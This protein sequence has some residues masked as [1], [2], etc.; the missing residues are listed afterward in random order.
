MLIKILE[1]LIEAIKIF[2]KLFQ[3][4]KKQPPKS[5]NYTSYKTGNNTI[6]YAGGNVRINQEVNVYNDKNPSPG[7]RTINPS[8]LDD[9]I[10]I[11]IESVAIDR[12]EDRYIAPDAEERFEKVRQ[13][14]LEKQIR[15]ANQGAP[16][17][18]AH[19]RELITM[20]YSKTHIPT[21]A[22][23]LERSVTSIHMELENLG[24]LKKGTRL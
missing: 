4:R 3:M 9:D 8:C 24:I 12:G 17:T 16:W 18:R 5:G 23:V 21:I 10:L 22:D 11:T 15:P 2:G 14:N 1:L 6:G 13:D 19:V 20:F 7:T